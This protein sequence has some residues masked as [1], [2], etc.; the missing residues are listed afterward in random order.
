M[1]LYQ[2]MCVLSSL[3]V[4]G[5]ITACVF[6]SLREVGCITTPIRGETTTTCSGVEIRGTQGAGAPLP[7]SHQQASLPANLYKFELVH[8]SIFLHHCDQGSEVNALPK[9]VGRLTKMSFPS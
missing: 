8:P 2:V 5:Y 7:A 9:P 3:I 6:G 1:L 4:S